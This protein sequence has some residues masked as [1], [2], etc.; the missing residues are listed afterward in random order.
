MD[1][2]IDLKPFKFWCQKVLPLIYDDSLSYYELLCKVVDY[3]NN[4]MTDVTVLHDEFVQLQNWVNDYFE[5]LDVQNEINNKLD[6]MAEDGTLSNLLEPYL[7]EFN[8]KIS[9]QDESIAVLN[10]RVDNLSKLPDGS[11]TGDAE[12]TDIRI[13]ADGITY[14]N[15]GES[16]RTQVT[17]VT[18][19]IN[20]VTGINII[21]PVTGWITGKYINF[22]GEELDYEEWKCSDFIEIPTNIT[23]LYLRSDLTTDEKRFNAFYDINKKFV[24]R[25]KLNENIDIKGNYK[26]LRVS[27]KAENEVKMLMYL[28]TNLTEL[29]KKIN[30]EIVI[31]E[32]LDNTYINFKGDLVEYNNWHS[33]N[34]IDLSLT[35]N[36]KKVLITCDDTNIKN[37]RFNAYYDKDKK[38]ISRLIQNET[39]VVPANAR[40]VRISSKSSFYPHF[41]YESDF[42]DIDIFNR[43]NESVML[44]STKTM[45]QRLKKDNCTMKLTILHMSDIHGRSELFNRIFQYSSKYPSNIDLILHTGDYVYKASDTFIDL[46]NNAPFTNVPFYNVIGNHDQYKT[47]ADRQQIDIKQAYD[48]V[49]TKTQRD[50]QPINVTPFGGETTLSY[51]KD[52][53]KSNIRLIVLDDY[54]NHESQVSELPTILADAKKKGYSVITAKHEL[55]SP[56]VTKV[57]NFNELNFYNSTYNSDF[58]DILKEFIGNGGIHI[59]N[60]CGHEHIDEMGYDKN[61]IL[62]IAIECATDDTYWQNN[63][64]SRNTKGWDCFNIFTVDTKRGFLKIVRVG[65]DSNIFTQS[66]KAICYDYINKKII[67][68]Y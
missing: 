66:K 38:F 49:I 59:C 6:E 50:W 34:Y 1:N 53:N 11:T 10:S 44:N 60:L 65:D 58:S 68:N 43:N 52:F 15:A 16:V 21:K 41:L 51:Y 63:E 67:E 25:A 2:Y 32:Y 55:T 36:V 40:Y 56:I 64:R 33:T 39:S 57:G 7:N 42:A 5:N 18:N 27:V 14:A 28:S 23:S 9:K 24:S 17:D 19:A 61:G 31:N 3:L 12:L 4:T 30:K 54:Y 62:N 47:D 26:Y 45:N 22:K 46:F 35:D 20:N 8:T 13:G 29:S 48:N 37:Y